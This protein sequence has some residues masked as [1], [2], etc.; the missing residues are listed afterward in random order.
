MPQP[1]ITRRAMLGRTLALGCSAAAS[2]LIT[3]VS[4]AAAP[5]D[6]RLVVIILRG[7]MDGLDVVQPYGDPGYAAARPTLRGGEAGGALDLDGFYA[8]HPALSSLM[9][10]W[11]A[12]QF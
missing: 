3:P 6:N 9:P 1:P 2:P 5:F 11:R 8:L 12:G 10:M 7:A 4:F